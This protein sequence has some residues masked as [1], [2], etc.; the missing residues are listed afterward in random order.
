MSASPS[1]A[2]GSYV[3]VTWPGWCALAAVVLLPWAV[4]WRNRSA[5][6]SVVR[7]S[8][9]SPAALGQPGQAP[10]SSVVGRGRQG[11][12]G[13]LEF[14][15][16]LIEPTEDF[17][18][19]ST[20]DPRPLKWVFSGYTDAAL[21]ALWQRAGL[22]D[23]ERQVLG[24]PANRERVGDAIVIRPP[25][26]LVL[27]LSASARAAIYIALAAFPEN[28]PQYDSYR[29]NA[30]A[31][32]QWLDSDLIAP[33]VI[34][35]IRPLLYPRGPNLMYSDVD[36]ILPRLGSVQERVRLAKN[37]SR[38]S[39]LLVQVRVEHKDDAEALARYWGRGGRSKDVE[40]LLQSLIQRPE[41]GSIDIVHLL[42]VFAR[43]LLYT[44]PTPSEDPRA[45]ARDCHWTS[46]NFF[47]QTPDDRF[48]NLE[49]VLKSLQSDYYPYGGEPA[50]GDIALLVT[51]EGQGIHSCVYVADGIVFTKNGP[52]SSVPWLLA[53]LADV[54]AF[55]PQASR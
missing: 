55:T 10:S 45:A 26:D 40:P 6:P 19:P 39:A 29:I 13:R 41:G 1:P 36:L 43:A 17:I 33:N 15:R 54:E 14:S 4:V 23:R 34:A 24:A 31:A 53:P 11:P 12:W 52:A 37:L 49:Q 20:L 8:A 25:A 51:A 38:R 27:G 2:R 16:I 28:I 35:M 21:E 48:L 32:D 9:A 7:P 30:N 18:R 44:Y 5:S 3:R 47:N 22:T 50:L 46:L 42:P